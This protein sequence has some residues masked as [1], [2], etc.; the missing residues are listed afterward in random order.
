PTATTMSDIASL[1]D[2]GKGGLAKGQVL[3]SGLIGVLAELPPTDGSEIAVAAVAHVLY[4]T[5][6]RPWRR[7]GSTRAKPQGPLAINLDHDGALR[8]AEDR[9]TH[10]KKGWQ[11]N[12]PKED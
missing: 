1:Q 11:F 9:L 2:T 6:S 7:V 8:E 12:G 5:M 3:A 10:E 4:R